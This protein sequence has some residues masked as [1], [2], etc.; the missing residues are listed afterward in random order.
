M[1][2]YSY[3]LLPIRLAIKK[4]NTPTYYPTNIITY[5]NICKD[6]SG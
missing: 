6:Q 1:N 5:N 4:I 2:G 3:F